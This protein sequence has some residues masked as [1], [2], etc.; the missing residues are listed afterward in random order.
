MASIRLCII[1][2]LLT[3]LTGCSAG[4]KPASTSSLPDTFTPAAQFSA[5]SAWQYI[6]DQVNFGPR[7]PGSAAHAACH[8]Y[9]VDKLTAIGAE[10][11]LLDTIFT[12]PT[13][14]RVPI[15]N[16]M[17]TIRPEARRQV[18][19]LAHYDTRPW[20]D[21]DS[22]PAAYKTPIDGANDGASGVGVILELARNAVSADPEVG[23]QILFVDY[24]DSGTYT[25]DDNEWCLGSQAFAASITPSYVRPDY[26]LLLDMVGGRGA[27]FPRE[28]FSAAYASP[29]SDRIVRAAARAGYA[30]R[31]PDR[32][33]MAVNDDH[34]PLLAAGI[35]T[36]DIIE[37]ANSATGSF[38]PTWHTL[39]DTLEHI[40]KATL[41]AVGD[42]VTEAIYR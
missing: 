17:A 21:R 26:A 41:K 32:V 7:V 13:G 11:T 2:L 8:S 25:G 36:V 4:T 9:L 24:E 5:D 27:S 31:F 12:S 38:N 15:H 30:D 1:S 29:V 35:P 14:E 20:A 16:I 28:Y 42:V 3:A 6:A 40:D 10:V 39:D 23:L 34:I 22:D 33:A 18:M 19:L 37:C